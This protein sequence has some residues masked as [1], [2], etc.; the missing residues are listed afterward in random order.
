MAVCVKGLTLSLQATRTCVN[1][2]TCYNDT[3]VA[4]DLRHLGVEIN[5]NCSS[6]NSKLIQAHQVDGRGELLN[7]CNEMQ[8]LTF[9]ST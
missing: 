9:S 6:R 8:K 7:F 1:F 3:L 4:K 2:S 5:L